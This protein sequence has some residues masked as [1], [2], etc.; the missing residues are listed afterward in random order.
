MPSSAII[1]RVLRCDHSGYCRSLVGDTYLCHVQQNKWILSL[2]LTICIACASV[3]VWTA[4][5]RK[6]L[7]DG[8]E[9]SI[10]HW[11]SCDLSLS[12]QKASRF[13][14]AWSC[15]VVFD[16]VVFTLT[17]VKA[18]KSDG[19]WRGTLFRLMLR[20]GSIYYGIMAMANVVNI[21][22]LLVVMPGGKGLF[23]TMTNVMSSLLISRLMLNLRGQDRQSLFSEEIELVPL[24]SDPQST[25]TTII[26]RAQGDIMSSREINFAL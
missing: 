12:D 13:A 5:S 8:S 4:F 11:P 14:I 25:G 2:L 6:A 18:M 10:P 21:V 23:T 24:E 7:N 3:I 20:D 17:I 9:L 26:F 22:T 19:L 1:S 16:T 15:L